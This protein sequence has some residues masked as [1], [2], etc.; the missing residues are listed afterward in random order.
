MNS[1][2]IVQTG[3]KQYRVAEGDVLKAE[4]LEAKAGEEVKLDEVLFAKADGKSLAGRPKVL[5]AS[6]TV[7]PTRLSTLC[8]S[9][10]VPP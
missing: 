9:R 5:G 1:Y 2:A 8:S 4:K 7:T 6:V 10:N 3:G